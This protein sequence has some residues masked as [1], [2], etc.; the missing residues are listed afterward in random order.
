MRLWAGGRYPVGSADQT[1]LPQTSRGW[2]IFSQGDDTE[3]LR[4]FLQPTARKGVQFTGDAAAADTGAASLIDHFVTIDRKARRRAKLGRKASLLRALRPAGEQ[5]LSSA[6]LW[7][8]PAESGTPWPAPPDTIPEETCEPGRTSPRSLSESDLLDLDSGDTLLLVQD[9]RAVAVAGAGRR[10]AR[11]QSSAPQ[12]ASW[13]PPAAAARQE[14][15]GA[16]LLAAEPAVERRGVGD[17]PSPGGAASVFPGMECL[18]SAGRARR[19]ATAAPPLT[20]M[21]D[22]I[23]EQAEPASLPPDI[24]ACA[25][26]R[27]RAGDAAR[28]RTV[29]ALA[30]DGAAAPALGAARKHDTFSIFQTEAEYEDLRYDAPPESAAAGRRSGAE[31]RR[32]HS[33]A[34]PSVGE[35]LR[36]FNI[37][38]FNYGS[39]LSRRLYLPEKDSSLDEAA[40]GG[41][42]CGPWYDLWAAD[43]SCSTQVQ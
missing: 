33:V 8:T 1:S 29:G 6:Q 37:V 25:A 5:A 28:R 39:F 30:T 27:R 23:G 2:L 36:R 32:H 3:L 19:A 41:Q 13:S 24:H 34:A 12:P 14:S 15:A 43:D 26:R 42:R 35:K 17:S 21:T 38:L 16:A 9:Y 20:S 7:R 31:L 18:R 11:A 22:V 40:E 10:A 4:P